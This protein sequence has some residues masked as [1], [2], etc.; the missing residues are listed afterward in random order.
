MPR[1]TTVDAIREALR[2]EL[3][4]D[5]RVVLMGEDVRLGV[6][7][8]TRWLHREFGDER[9]SSTRLSRSWRLPAPASARLRPACAL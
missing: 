1:I 9:E 8:G 5:E 2:A 4:R 3:Q 7:A 6:F